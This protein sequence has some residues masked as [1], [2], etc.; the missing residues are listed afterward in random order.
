[1][2]D[3]AQRLIGQR[4]LQRAAKRLA[5]VAREDE[6]HLERPCADRQRRQDERCVANV[7]TDVV[8]EHADAVVADATGR[9]DRGRLQLI[10]G[11]FGQI[12]M[13]AG[14]RDG[15]VRVC[16][17]NRLQCCVDR[18]PLRAVG[19]KVSVER[20]ARV[21]TNPRR[22]DPT[23]ALTP[24]V[25]EHGIALLQYDTSGG[26]CAQ[27][28][29]DSAGEVLAEVCRDEAFKPHVARI[30]AVHGGGGR[31]LD[32]RADLEMAVA[33]DGGDEA[34]LIEKSHDVVESAL[35]RG[36]RRGSRVYARGVRR[37]ARM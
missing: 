15:L 35:G 6:W 12:A 1:M 19:E 24:S 33:R 27:V 3:A 26:P 22:S 23:Q 31:L 29:L 37:V 28:R 16:A 7:D 14:D 20:L 9:F 8:G 4:D 21:K 10:I 30:G 34:G 13:Y 32:D 11:A 17:R 25:D 18:V 36:R 5:V 2:P